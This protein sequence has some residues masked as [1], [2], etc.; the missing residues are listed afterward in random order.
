[1]VGI[2]AGG[3]VGF[4]VLLFRLFLLSL[5]LSWVAISLAF[6]YFAF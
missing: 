6:S 1:V 4:V 3:L 5:V 2:L